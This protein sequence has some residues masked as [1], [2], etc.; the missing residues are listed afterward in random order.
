M[1]TF[2]GPLGVGLL[3]GIAGEHL[4]GGWGLILGLII[5]G[6]VGWLLAR[7]LDALVEWLLPAGLLGL[8]RDGSRRE[9]A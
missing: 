2:F 9:K 8:W 6:A 4:G 3:G 5:G 7:I 1:T